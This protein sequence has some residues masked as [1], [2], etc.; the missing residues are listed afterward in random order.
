MVS[1]KILVKIVFVVIGLAVCAIGAFSI[2]VISS[3]GKFPPYLL[4]R[5]VLTLFDKYG[6]PP[7]PPKKRVKRPIDIS[8]KIKGLD[9]R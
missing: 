6:P 5:K 1:W 7:P 3:A 9:V 2:G 8:D 4:S